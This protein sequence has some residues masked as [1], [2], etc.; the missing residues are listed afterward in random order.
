MSA[1]SATHI[2]VRVALINCGRV[3]RSAARAA[4]RITIR[5]KPNRGA[6]LKKML[7]MRFMASAKK[8]FPILS[9]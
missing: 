3:R 7:S 1:N 4:T 9:I 5:R 8:R 2:A 6:I